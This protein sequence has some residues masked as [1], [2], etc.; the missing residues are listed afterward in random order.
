MPSYSLC[1]HVSFES[2]RSVYVCLLTVT[3][4]HA[5]NMSCILTKC[6]GCSFSADRTQNF[7]PSIS[8]KQLVKQIIRCN[9][10]N[11]HGKLCEG[12]INISVLCDHNL[13]HIYGLLPLPSSETS[14]AALKLLA[15]RSRAFASPPSASSPPSSPLSFAASSP[16]CAARC[17]ACDFAAV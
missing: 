11:S 5:Q 8:K 15:T 6:K 17:W 9:Q 4:S 1:F 12:T 2:L 3:G 7:L 16:A 13:A 10:P 14:T